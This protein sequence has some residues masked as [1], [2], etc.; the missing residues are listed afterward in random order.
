MAPFR[1][2]REFTDCPL[3]GVSKRQMAEARKRALLRRWLVRAGFP[4]RVLHSAGLRELQLMVRV[5]RRLSKSPSSL[6]SNLCRRV[7]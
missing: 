6:T 2:L 1:P 4:G 7:Q 3:S 5:T